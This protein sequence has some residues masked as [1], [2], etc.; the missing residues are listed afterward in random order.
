M[1]ILALALLLAGTS[2]SPAMAAR[3]G[4]SE[5]VERLDRSASEPNTQIADRGGRG[6][7]WQGGGNHGGGG[8]NGGGAGNGGG[9][10]RQ[11]GGGTTTPSTGGWQGRSSGESGGWRQRSAPQVSTPTPQVQAPVQ[12]TWNGGGNPGYE[13]GGN[14]WQRR[15]RTVTT[16]TPVPGGTFDRN[17]NGR[18]D[19]TWD[20]NRNG[21]VDRQWDRN[22]DGNLDRRWDRNGNGN[23]DRRWDRNNDERLDRRWDRNRNG[24]VDQYGY[25]RGG[26]D[27]ND[28]NR[29]WRNDRR[30][31][32]NSYRNYNRDYYRLPRYVNPYGYSYGYRRFNV[33]FYLDSLFYSSAYW[34]DDPWS[35]RLPPAYGSYRW[36]RYYDDVMLI[37]MRTGFVVDVIYSFFW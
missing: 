24:R 12:R 18:V 8:W 10:W 7:G 23:L 13:G 28:W 2:I 33:G 36:V 4:Q 9:G 19:R 17:A 5:R 25:D 20:R 22:R 15:D 3:E 11:S 1:R 16:P 6:G 26:R 14:R 21:V 29:S 32:W 31:D 37:D 30:Y 34:L 35:Y 27:R